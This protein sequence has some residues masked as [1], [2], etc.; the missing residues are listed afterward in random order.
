[1]ENP[2]ALLA[3]LDNDGVLVDYRQ[4]KKAEHKTKKG[5]VAVPDDC[6][7]Q[8]GRYRWT[9]EEFLPIHQQ[10]TG[11]PSP[12]AV[13]AIALGFAELHNKRIVDLPGPTLLWLRDYEKSFDNRQL[14]DRRVRLTR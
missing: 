10:M 14:E 5:Q 3:I 12:T 6:D 1:M 11:E 7:L 9:G 13:H 8:I 2:M 4:C